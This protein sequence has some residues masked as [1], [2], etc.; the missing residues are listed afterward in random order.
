MTPEHVYCLTLCADGRWLLLNRQYKPF[1]TGITEWVDYDTSPGIRVRLTAMQLARLTSLG[2]EP[3]RRWGSVK[4]WLYKEATSPDRS[5]A[6]QIAHAV[7]SAVLDYYVEM[8]RA[9]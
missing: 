2:H 6:L 7:R 1:G 3:A 4:M 9:A 5:R 8:E